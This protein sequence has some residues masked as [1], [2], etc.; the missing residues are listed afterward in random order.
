MMS[1]R[2]TSVAGACSSTARLLQSSSPGG[3]RACR[4]AV[5]G[6]PPCSPETG[7]SGHVERR[8]AHAAAYARKGRGC[9]SAYDRPFNQETK[10]A[11]FPQISVV[12]VMQWQVPRIQ[13]VLK[14]VKVPINLEDQVSWDPTETVHRQSCRHT[15]GDAATGPSYS[16]GVEDHG[17]PDHPGDLACRVPTDSVRQGCCRY[18]CGDAVKGPSD[19]E[20]TEDSGKSDQPGDQAC[21]VPTDT[22]TKVVVDTPVVMQRQVP[23]IR[24]SDKSR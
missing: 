17:N 4:A 3:E 5:A 7:C 19:S 10:H 1:V 9:V 16:D 13:T 18:A 11:E 12:V 21:R 2:G 23:Q 6:P 8:R 15:Y 24:V 22:S 20:C 14:T